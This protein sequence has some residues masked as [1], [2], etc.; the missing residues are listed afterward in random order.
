MSLSVL[1]LKVSI[2]KYVLDWTASF[3]GW[4]IHVIKQNV[5]LCFTFNLWM[6]L[7]F[8]SLMTLILTLFVF[9]LGI[10]MASVTVVSQCLPGIY[11]FILRTFLWGKETL[12]LGF[13]DWELRQRE[14]RLQESCSI[15]SSQTL[16]A[17]KFI[18][19]LIPNPATCIWIFFILP[20]FTTLFFFFFFSCL[21]FSSNNLLG[22]GRTCG[23][24]D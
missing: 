12:S 11:G 10:F 21:R 17:N 20:L 13:T 16:I 3:P 9:P 4:R 19:V 7:L 5:N 14:T 6:S 1:V 18:I 23:K 22:A 2:W 15:A 24:Y 8:W